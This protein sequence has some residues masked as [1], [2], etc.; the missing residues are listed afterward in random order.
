MQ[1][2]TFLIVILLRGWNYN[3]DI[4]FKGNSRPQ[5]VY[6]QN[7]NLKH[8]FHNNMPFRKAGNRSKSKFR[9][10]SVWSFFKNGK[11]F[12]SVYTL[13][14]L[15]IPK[16]HTRISTFAYMML[17]WLLCSSLILFTYF[18]AR[19]LVFHQHTEEK[20][21]TDIIVNLQRVHTQIWVRNCKR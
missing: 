14:M 12:V 19:H 15:C 10:L 5:T 21:M 2:V 9:C 4:S 7:Y 3:Q 13:R 18:T 16:T 8:F 17:V 6:F 1:I 20:E 11:R